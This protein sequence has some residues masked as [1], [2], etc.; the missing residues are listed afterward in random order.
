[1]GLREHS[2]HHFQ[3]ASEEMERLQPERL[4]LA[5]GTIERIVS[6]EEGG[7]PRR[8]RVKERG[9]SLLLDSL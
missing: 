8:R 9:L 4:K 7:N 3:T 6:L 1:L 5:E 2:I